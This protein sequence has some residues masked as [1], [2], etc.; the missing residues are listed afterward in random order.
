MRVMRN[1]KIFAVLFAL[2]ITLGAN[3]VV[4]AQNGNPRLASLMSLLAMLDL[5][6]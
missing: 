4:L 1:S 3:L 6:I 5:K 2:S